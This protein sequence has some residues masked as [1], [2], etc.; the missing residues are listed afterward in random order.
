MKIQIRVLASH[1]LCCIV[2]ATAALPQI[3]A[4]SD[5][6]A[7]NSPAGPAGRADTFDGSD[8]AAQREMQ[9]DS[10]MNSD[11]LNNW[12]SNAQVLDNV[13][14]DPESKRT[15]LGDSGHSSRSTTGPTGSS[16]DLGPRSESS[17][18]TSGY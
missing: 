13:D 12:D 5:D 14:N 3:V 18:T 1:A 11:G 17:A 9:A 10:S 15:N 16:I 8:L 2:F 6:D 7:F 4:Q